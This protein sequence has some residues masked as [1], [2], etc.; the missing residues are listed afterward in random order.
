MSHTLQVRLRSALSHASNTGLAPADA[1]A[2]LVAQ[3]LDDLPM[4]GAGATLHRWRA[5]GGG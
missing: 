5:G 4:P 1:L 3:K 2:A